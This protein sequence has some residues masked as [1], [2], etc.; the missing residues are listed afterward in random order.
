MNVW[1]HVREPCKP[2]DVSHQDEQSQEGFPT[3]LS[4][5]YIL[6]LSSSTQPLV[7]R[8]RVA[9]TKE[10]KGE[11][12]R[13]STGEMVWGPWCGWCQ[14][15]KTSPSPTT[16]P[17]LCPCLRNGHVK[18]TRPR[19][20]RASPSITQGGWDLHKGSAVCRSGLG[21]MVFAEYKVTV[22]TS[23]KGFFTFKRSN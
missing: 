13:H 15:R 8:S 18:N 4:S 7:G 23:E 22:G 3:S 12:D 2:T 14:P 11:G 20:S 21:R 5:S 10:K 16:P 17:T 6:I 9:T 19:S 1:A